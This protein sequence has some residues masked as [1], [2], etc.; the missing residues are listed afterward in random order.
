LGTSWSS[1]A[2]AASFSS[3]LGRSGAVLIT[4]SWLCSRLGKGDNGSCGDGMM[5]FSRQP[6]MAKVEIMLKYTAQGP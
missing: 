5:F 3:Q 1:P 4:D 6:S 2:T